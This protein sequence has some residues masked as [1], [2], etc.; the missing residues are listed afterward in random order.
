MPVTFYQGILFVLWRNDLKVDFFIGN[1]LLIYMF[2]NKP[3]L[4]GYGYM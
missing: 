3:I 2:Y 4:D 1:C